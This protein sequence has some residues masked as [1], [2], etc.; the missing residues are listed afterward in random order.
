MAD[1][2]IRQTALESFVTCFNLCYPDWEVYGRSSRDLTAT[3][4]NYSYTNAKWAR[5]GPR[6]NGRVYFALNSDW[7]VNASP[8]ERIGLLIHELAHVKET[9]HSPEFWEQVVTNFESLN[10][11]K[12][13]VEETIEGEADWEEV[14]E[15]IVDD[16]H[17]GL[18]DNRSEIAYERRRKLAAA[19]D[20]SD[21]EIEPFGNM[22]IYTRVTKQSEKVPL[23]QI[24]YEEAT[25]DEIVS[26]FHSRPRDY[27]SKHKTR[28]TITELPARKSGQTYELVEGDEMATLAALVGRDRLSI[29]VVNE[30]SVNQQAQRAKADD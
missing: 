15:F 30:R 7:Y 19:L 13:P 10:A 4:V 11:N 18:V 1:S 26:Y 5:C 24:Q 21:D 14:K 12:A 16:P 6:K 22:H 27:L 8:A 9:N 29:D 2:N 28:Y 20:Y 17:T 3:E 23:G 25:I